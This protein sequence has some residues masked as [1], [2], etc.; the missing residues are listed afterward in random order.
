MKAMQELSERHRRWVANHFGGKVKELH[1]HLAAI[2][3]A[4]DHS[5]QLFASG[6]QVPS[7]N[8]L[9][10]VY[11]FST[12]AN[13]IQT[14]KD[15]T[16]TVTGEQLPWSTIKLLRH[17]SFMKDAR[18]AAT[19]DGNPVVSAW[20]D[21]R[22]FVPG[23]ITRLGDNGQVIEIPAPA[24][25]VR[26]LC[27]EFAEDFC[28][29][30]LET[31]LGMENVAHLEGASFSMAEL[32]EAITESKV[33]PEFAKELFASNRQEIA[34]SLRDAKHDPVAQ[35]IGHLDEVIRYCELIQ[36]K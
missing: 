9:A 19:H 11:G 21:G 14:L 13:V 2:V 33:M 8:S 34:A 16:K 18:N 10:L 22:Y 23:K 6:H 27:L 15:A 17:G 31:L 3:A 29:L 20:V 35:A 12:Y 1:Y 26:T 24:E 36:K 30:L 4:S 28:R 5:L 32:E 7:A 25:D